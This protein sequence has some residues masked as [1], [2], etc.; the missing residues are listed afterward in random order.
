MAEFGKTTVKRAG[1]Q[2]AAQGDVSSGTRALARGLSSFQNPLNQLAAVEGEKRIQLAKDN[3]RREG[4]VRGNKFT[5]DGTPIAPNIDDLD[6]STIFGRNTAAAAERSYI[7]N[8][9][10]SSKAAAAGLVQK[11][12]GNTAVYE[13][14]AQDYRDVTLENIPDFFRPQAEAELNGA[15]ALARADVLIQEQR[16]VQ[17]NQKASL[18]AGEIT[19]REN[20]RT[21]ALQGDVETARFALLSAQ[22]DVQ[23]Q[24]DGGYMTPAEGEL[25]QREIAVDGVQFAGEADLMQTLTEAN[26]PPL[27]RIS[28]ALV[29]NERL[30][31]LPLSEIGLESED[32]RERVSQNLNA[33]IQT[34]GARLQQQA[35][36]RIIQKSRVQQANDRRFAA[37]LV[38]GIGHSRAELTAE[39]EAEQISPEFYLSAMKG[40]NKRIEKGRKLIVDRALSEYT[41]GGMSHSEFLNS[42]AHD[43]MTG[44]ERLDA[45]EEVFERLVDIGKKNA[46]HAIQDA[47]LT[48]SLSPP[49]FDKLVLSLDPDNRR[50]RLEA[51]VRK[52]YG[53]DSEH[54]MMRVAGENAGR[55]VKP[56]TDR[57]RRGFR[58][59]HGPE[60]FDITGDQVDL[61]L[62]AETAKNLGYVDDQAAKQFKSLVNTDNPAVIQSTVGAFN[63][64]CSA[65]NSV[66]TDVQ[67][68]TLRDAIGDD[69]FNHYEEL[70]LRIKDG[71]D[72]E[73]VVNAAQE[74]RRFTASQKTDRSSLDRSFASGVGEQ[75]KNEM[76]N[77]SMEALFSSVDNAAPGI[78]NSLTDMGARIPILKHLF[79][80]AD[81]ELK[82]VLVQNP[83]LVETIPLQDIQH[84]IRQEY[85]RL[86]AAEPKGK[87]L[88]QRRSD[89]LANM[90]ARAWGSKNQVVTQTQVEFEQRDDGSFDFAEREE[91]Q[92]VRV[93]RNG[94]SQSYNQDSPFTWTSDMVNL[95]LTLN[96]QNAGM[97]L[98][99][100]M[101]G[102]EWTDLAMR[103]EPIR[104]QAGKH[105]V[106]YVND[107][108]TEMP[109]MV[110]SADGRTGQAVYTQQAVLD[111]IHGEFYKYQS[112]R[113]M[114]KASESIPSL[115]IWLREKRVEALMRGNLFTSGIDDRNNVFRA[116]QKGM[117]EAGVDATDQLRFMPEEGR[118]IFQ[119][120]G[121]GF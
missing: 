94:I 24:V 26:V 35:N 71:D 14:L 112:R 6:R 82:K 100:E 86:L 10:T 1:V 80:A 42:P 120:T 18:V 37:D 66:D 76:A 90:A 114:A 103:T 45:E 85:N 34:E 70:S 32:E 96:F 73:A 33:I 62:M 54:R 43:M 47:E 19:H 69:A 72:P 121:T 117:T 39:F 40:D 52:W 8:L 78:I 2:S 65:T 119:Q 106:F 5:P 41:R 67:C 48:G 91:R 12:N 116:L 50:A 44:Q 74:V 29:Q 93:E 27:Q 97:A 92:V 46:D 51:Y 87:I 77:A 89:Q 102:R 88:D 22:A 20:A 59:L 83:D 115:G 75:E 56:I 60:K 38:N 15:L 31:A 55:G 99:K 49:G 68:A 105:R 108:G 113:G 17:A 79:Q 11:A 104:G 95:E 61:G 30:R 111:T 57:Q 81:P 21:A 110:Q 16:Q 4:I 63:A 58:L 25:R 101:Q 28:N 36:L 3:A 13:E 118:I 109:L 23:A 9:A 7:S 64:I 98:P 84:G 107:E 53:T